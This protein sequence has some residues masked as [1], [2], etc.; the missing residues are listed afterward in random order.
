MF[1]YSTKNYR[2]ALIQTCCGTKPSLSQPAIL[3]YLKWIAD[4][5][6]PGHSS[7]LYSWI[8]FQW[9][10]DLHRKEGFTLQFWSQSWGQP[11]H[12]S[13]PGAGFHS[14][15]SLQAAQ[16]ESSPIK[17]GSYTKKC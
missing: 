9:K 13:R 15:D 12:A 2:I 8:Y 11:K 4:Q 6:T 3:N 16:T 14:T 17:T 1:F 10:P 5:S 7:N